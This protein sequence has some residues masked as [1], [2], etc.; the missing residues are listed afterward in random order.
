MGFHLLLGFS[1]DSQ[2]LKSWG[3]YSSLSTVLDLLLPGLSHWGGAA[4]K[5]FP[6]PGF[7]L[8]PRVLER[9]GH[10][11]RETRL[12]LWRL[13][14]HWLKGSLQGRSWARAH[15]YLFLTRCRLGFTV[16][17][18][19]GSTIDLRC[20]KHFFFWERNHIFMIGKFLSELT[21]PVTLEASVWGVGRGCP[22]A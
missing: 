15:L 11:T 2:P 8:T 22:P 14:R 19:V 16:S 17:D 1:A 18:G 6:F 10:V 7:D 20:C 3:S 4:G 5:R 21:L 12:F 13:T 9:E